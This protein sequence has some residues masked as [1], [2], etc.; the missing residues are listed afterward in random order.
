MA[1]L[2][3][4]IDLEYTTVVFSEPKT[5]TLKDKPDVKY[6]RVQVSV[7][8]DDGTTCPLI[9]P[10]DQ[11][12]SYGIQECRFP[13]SDKVNGYSLP[14]VMYD[15]NDDG[16]YTPATHQDN[17]V[18]AFHSVVQQAKD[19]LINSGLLKPH[20]LTKLGNCMFGPDGST[21]TIGSH[22]PQRF[23]PPPP[24]GRWWRASH[25]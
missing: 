20:K 12:F 22:E 3:Q 10:T 9:V 8:N 2:T 4:P 1:K 16:V 15:R 18:M 11:S 6:V 21:S 14:I 24:S 7:L 5:G 25:E 17:F 13:N 19:H 23:S